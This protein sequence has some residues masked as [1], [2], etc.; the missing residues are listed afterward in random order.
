MDM[1]DDGVEME[2]EV[3]SGTFTSKALSV[4]GRVLESKGSEITVVYGSMVGDDEYFSNFAAK[5][6]KWNATS[7]M[8]KSQR[9]KEMPSRP[10]YAT[11]ATKPHKATK[12]TTLV[13]SEAL[14][15][16]R[17]KTQR[18]ITT[19]SLLTVARYKTNQK[20]FHS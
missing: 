13:L 6:T 7:S 3:A 19:T 16:S 8:V 18:E 17:Q 14:Q 11:T 5:T 10:F 1:V 20:H 15:P 9:T 4:A 12:A 2:I